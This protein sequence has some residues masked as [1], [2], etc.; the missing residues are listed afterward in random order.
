MSRF[1]ALPATPGYTSGVHDRQ[2]RPACRRHGRP[3]HHYPLTP[4]HLPFVGATGKVLE[5]L[6]DNHEHD[7]T[8]AL[9]HNS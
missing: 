1:A 5:S 9:Y 8:T 3:Q 2:E 4:E 7:L 6:E